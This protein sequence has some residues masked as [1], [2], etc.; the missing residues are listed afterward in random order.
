MSWPPD[1]AA[2]PLESRALRR[3]LFACDDPASSSTTSA[4]SGRCLIS[5]TTFASVP[6]PR[7]MELN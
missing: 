5:L 2:A 6:M 1:D 7:M 4:A 3:D